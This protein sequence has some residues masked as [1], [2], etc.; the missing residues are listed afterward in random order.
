MANGQIGV[1]KFLKRRNTFWVIGKYLSRSPGPST[2]RQVR[3]A[4]AFT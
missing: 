4:S 1:S 2:F 3:D